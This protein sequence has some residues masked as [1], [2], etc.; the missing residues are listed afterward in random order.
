[1]TFEDAKMIEILIISL[2]AIFAVYLY[3]TFRDQRKVVNIEYDKRNIEEIFAKVHK[4]LELI[5]ELSKYLL[6]LKADMDRLNANVDG[7]HAKLK[8]DDW[9]EQYESGI[10]HCAGFDLDWE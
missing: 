4:E 9:P 2:V 1:M 7:R 6:P 5:T 3:M 10:T 8:I